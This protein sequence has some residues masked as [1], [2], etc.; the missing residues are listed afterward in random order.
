MFSYKFS[1]RSYSWNLKKAI[2]DIF[3]VNALGL[4]VL[5]GFWRKNARELLGLI[6]QLVLI[7]MVSKLDMFVILESS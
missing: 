3:V 4:A 5:S 2:F 7:H 6:I 1:T